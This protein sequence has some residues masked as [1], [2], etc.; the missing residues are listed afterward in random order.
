MADESCIHCGQHAEDDDR[1]TGSGRVHER[2]WDAFSEE[3]PVAKSSVVAGCFGLSMVAAGA[4]VLSI[5]LAAF[6]MGSSL[7]SANNQ[8]PSDGVFSDVTAST[9][10]GKGEVV[11]TFTATAGDPPAAVQMLLGK[12][13]VQSQADNTDPASTIAAADI[14]ASIVINVDL[15]PTD[16]L[17]ITWTIDVD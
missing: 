15:A 14:L 1:E 2:C 4:V 17:Q 11:E 3:K 16:T 5:G 9:T 10:D 12:F 13:P 7:D 6:A 8:N